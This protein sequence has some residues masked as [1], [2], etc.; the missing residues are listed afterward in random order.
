LSSTLSIRNFFAKQIPNFDT[1]KFITLS[2]I[3]WQF[4]NLLDKVF[5]EFIK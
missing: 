3:M 4:G 5:P 2:H 1:T